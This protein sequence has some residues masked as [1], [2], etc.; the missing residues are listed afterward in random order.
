MRSY[1]QAC[2]RSLASMIIAIICQ[3]IYTQLPQL[4]FAQE[5]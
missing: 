1:F 5:H 4:Y 2:V 3:G